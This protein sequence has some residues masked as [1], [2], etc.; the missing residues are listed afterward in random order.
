MYGSNDYPENT[1]VSIVSISFGI[2]TL[3][4]LV[5]LFGKRRSSKIT[6][7]GFNSFI[8]SQNTYISQ[9]QEAQIFR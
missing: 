8:Q 1:L 6:S 4:I 9:A 7:K 5:K 2:L 3:Q